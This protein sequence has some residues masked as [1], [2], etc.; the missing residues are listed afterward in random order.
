MTTAFKDLSDQAMAL[1]ALMSEK[2]KAVRAASRTASEEEVS[3]LVDHL[4][5]LTDYMT[6]MDEQVDGPDQQ[7]MLMAVAKPATEVMFEVGDM[8][9]DVYGHDPD[10]L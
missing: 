10:R 6:G 1:I 4:E 9:F 7:R 3:E 8:L 2:I 5:T